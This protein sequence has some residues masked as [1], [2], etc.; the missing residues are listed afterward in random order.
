MG[1][2]ELIFPFS[3]ED[4]EPQM[5]SIRQ[6][7]DLGYDSFNVFLN[8][9]TLSLLIGVYFA[10]FGFVFIFLKPISVIFKSLRPKYIKLRDDLFFGDILHIFKEGY[11][12]FL[13]STLMLILFAPKE[14]IDDKPY[15][16]VLAYICLAITVIL[17]P[18]IS[19]W[20]L[21]KKNLESISTPKFTRRWGVLIDGVNTK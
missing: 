11:M 16:V 1:L 6:I 17:I 19:I 3:E 8:L 5:D 12:E 21:S 7:R 15:M 9:G 13:I 4:S 18:S 10:K 20:I 14:S 2:L